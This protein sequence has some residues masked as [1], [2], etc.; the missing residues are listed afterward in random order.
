MCSPDPNELPS[1]TRLFLSEAPE[2]C[3][4][5]ACV[6]FLRL[7]YSI[8]DEASTSILARLFL[9]VLVDLQIAFCACFAS[10]VFPPGRLG[11]ILFQSA[12]A[13]PLKGRGIESL[14]DMDPSSDIQRQQTPGLLSWSP[15]ILASCSGKSA[16]SMATIDAKNGTVVGIRVLHLI[17]LPFHEYCHTT[18]TL[19]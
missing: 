13:H 1:G 17:C 11:N 15:R 2:W 7:S 4:I 9:L 18:E 16:R 12:S 6:T 10:T 5:Y 19:W 8:E 14:I 3:P